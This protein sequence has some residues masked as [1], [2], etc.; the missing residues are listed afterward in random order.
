M[1]FK[2][3]PRTIFLTCPETKNQ[4][5]DQTGF[6]EITKVFC[7][8]SEKS[9]P[10]TVWTCGPKV[11][12]VKVPG[13]VGNRQLTTDDGRPPCLVTGCFGFFFFSTVCRKSC[14]FGC[15]PQIWTQ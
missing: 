9:K 8:A 14:L 4:I 11:P 2:K 5:D 13:T 10:W 7:A 6:S 1:Q 12:G 3:V 15:G